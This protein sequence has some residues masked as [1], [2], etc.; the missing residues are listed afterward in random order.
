LLQVNSEEREPVVWEGRVFHTAVGSKEEMII[1]GGLINDG[2]H[3][4]DMLVYR[5]TCNTWHRIQFERTL[6]NC[7]A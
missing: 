2:I 3:A 5:Y 1:I 6:G 7:I 4:M